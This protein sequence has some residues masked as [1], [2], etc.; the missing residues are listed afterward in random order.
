M[1]YKKRSLIFLVSF[2]LT[3]VLNTSCIWGGQA[4]WQSL[5][6]PDAAYARMSFSPS[7]FVGTDDLQIERLVGSPAL[8]ISRTETVF[9]RGSWQFLEGGRFIFTP[10]PTAYVRQDVFPSTEH[11]PFPT[12]SLR[13][14]ERVN[15][16]KVTIPLALMA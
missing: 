14:K 5:S 15:L 16:R 13:C 1:T 4:A 2:L 12:T 9:L 10:S 7:T 8:G 6:T 3:I 11:T